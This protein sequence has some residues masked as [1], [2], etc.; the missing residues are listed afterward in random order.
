MKTNYI[1]VFIVCFGLLTSSTCLAQQPFPE[2][3]YTQHEFDSDTCC[4]RKLD[5]QKKYKQSAE[6]IVRYLQ[7]SPN[8]TNKHSLRWHAGQMYGF[9]QDNR[10]AITYM[11][12]TYNV[13]YKWFG[14]DDGRAWYNYAKGT[15]AFLRKDKKAIVKL[16]KKW[17]KGT[18]RDANYILLKRLHDNI[19]K[20]YRLAYLEPKG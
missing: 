13:F 9:A 17:E 19:D 3:N 10:Q 6:L 8:A 11:K 12:K 15:V 14:G 2:K 5:R 4:W 16:L 1:I 20:P 18:T 7:E